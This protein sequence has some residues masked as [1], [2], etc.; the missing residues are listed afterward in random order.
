[1]SAAH[2]IESDYTI[3]CSSHRK[4]EEF[5]IRKVICARHDAVA[6]FASSITALAGSMTVTEQA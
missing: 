6:A 1:M 2:R 5:D 3:F 4:K